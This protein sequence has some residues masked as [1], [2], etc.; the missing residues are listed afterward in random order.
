MRTSLC[1]LFCCLVMVLPMRGQTAEAGFNLPPTTQWVVRL[2]LVRL[3][4]T[5]L[6]KYMVT[7]LLEIAAAPTPELQEWIPVF[8]PLF[9]QASAV[10]FIGDERG[11]RAIVAAIEGGDGIR[12]EQVLGAEE[13]GES[14]R[15]GG[16]PIFTKLF[17]PEPGKPAV[18]FFVCRYSSQLTLLTPDKAALIRAAA[19]LNAHQASSQKTKELA[20]VFADKTSFISGVWQ[21]GQAADGSLEEMG[22]N[23]IQL[24][25]WTDVDMVRARCFFLCTDAK[26][27]H[28]LHQTVMLLQGAW[29]S[30]SPPNSPIA[31]FAKD[32]TLASVG[33]MLAMDYKVSHER[34]R[35][36]LEESGK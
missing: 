18:R 6:G 16:P 17:T 22:I 15:L 27:A 26:A 5:G 9:I 4:S 36:L 10:T 23:A 30:K 3:R 12:W 2:N 35:Q 13:S 1:L 28:D 14:L 8:G 21:A 32:V 20:L 33:R 29:V 24:L 31:V 11:D 34:I 25:A 19:A 7:D